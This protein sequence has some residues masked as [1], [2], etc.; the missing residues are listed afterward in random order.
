MFAPH[1][2]YYLHNFQQALDWLTARYDDLFA[3]AERAFVHDFGRLPQGSRALAVRLLMRT[4][5]VYRAEC[6]SYEEIGCIP[7]AAAP[8]LAL[9]WLRADPELDWAEWAA[10]HT[11][12]ELARR[13]P[14]AGA[15]A[16]WRKAELLAALREHLGGA[17]V[18][19]CG[20]WGADPGE[21]IWS[22]EI[23]ALAERLRLMFFGNLHQSWSEFVLADLGIF[24]YEPVALDASTRAFP[25]AG[26]I[27]T[28][29]ALHAVRERL[30]DFTADDAPALHA[31]IEAC[32]SEVPWL[33]RRQAKVWFRLGQACERAGAWSH[34]ETAYRA[35]RHPG[36][37]QRLIRVIERQA[38]HAEAHALAC[39]T[40]AAPGSEAE[41]QLVA[42]M[43]PRLA[44]QAG[45]P[46]PAR[47][48]GATMAPFE[49]VL[50]RPD[51]PR[52]VEFVVRDHLAAD[53]APAYYVENGL[54]NSL[55][56]LLCWRAIFEPVSGA[57]FHPFQRGPADLHDADFRARRAAAFEACLGALENG[58]HRERILACYEEKAGVQ[59]PF[60]FWGMLSRDLL[61]AALDCIAPEH[62]ALWFARLLD[63]I[64]T[65]R[66]GLPD[67]VRFWPAEARYELI[68]VKGPGDRLQD[69]QVRWL[70]YAA[71]HGLPVRV[72]HVRWDDA[73][74]DTIL[75]T[76][77]MPLAVAA[78]AGSP[79]AA[80]PEAA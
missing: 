51:P 75:A 15:R 30:D 23:V 47:A 58:T 54:I 78:T 33:A 74:P 62:L 13:Y 32:S 56:G 10:L 4:R 7:T 28:Y 27:D 36:A 9:G 37:R 48:R 8:L 17:D 43:L 61:E 70:T 22:V 35:S 31:E 39:E 64:E 79:A 24:Q 34:A 60:V 76:A 38:R 68:E 53:E 41:R 16:S 55:F 2:Y 29:L 73:A 25:H 80:L 77:A 40:L 49:L 67:L 46:V 65:N 12:D 5:R 18:R 20:A 45:L 11:K 3:P 57:F 26:A 72:C 21:A 63:D 19:T 52:R 66:S 69:N 42:R 50:P 71:R 1:R 44:R 14:Q 59:S 6:L